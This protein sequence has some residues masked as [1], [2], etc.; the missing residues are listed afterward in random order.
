[1]QAVN[2]KLAW[3]LIEQALAVGASDV[4]IEPTSDAVRIRVRVDGLLQ[5]L[6]R[7]PCS[8]HSTLVTQFKVAANMD[9]A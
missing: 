2:N 4:H 7:L 5:E 6:T 3:S 1:M 8:A 9:I